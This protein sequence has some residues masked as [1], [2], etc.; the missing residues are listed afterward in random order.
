MVVILSLPFAGLVVLDRVGFSG[1]YFL[2]LVVPD[3]LFYCTPQRIPRLSTGR[4]SHWMF[5]GLWV[6]GLVG[7]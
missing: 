7:S 3:F 6:R 1:D 5:M 2:F 4:C